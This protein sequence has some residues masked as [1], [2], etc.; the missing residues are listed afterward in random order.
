MQSMAL[1]ALQE[2][3]EMY[4]VQLFEDAVLASVHAKRK[5]MKVD[6]MYLVRRVRGRGD[7][8]GHRINWDA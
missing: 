1:Q 2:A 8:C 5:T 7:V 6:D 4:L 3:A